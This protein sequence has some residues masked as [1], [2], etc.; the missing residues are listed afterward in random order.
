MGNSTDYDQDIY[1][2]F[3]HGEFDSADSIKNTHTEKI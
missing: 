3:I 1:N 2:R